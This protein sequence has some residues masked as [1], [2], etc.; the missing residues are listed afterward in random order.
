MKTP[1]NVNS[2]ELENCC[3]GIHIN[4][5][6]KYMK[7]TT[8][9]NGKRI[10]ILIKKHC[11]LLYESLALDFYNPYEHQSKK[12]KGILVYVHSGIEYFL[13]YT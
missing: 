7:N 10:R 8:K 2:L 1:I 12:K 4:E 6:N 3:S 11:P 5:W 13:R 9:A